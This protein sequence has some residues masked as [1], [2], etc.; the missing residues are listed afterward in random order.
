VSALGDALMDEVGVGKAYH[1][2][3]E[4]DIANLSVH[5]PRERDSWLMKEYV[6][7]NYNSDDLRRL[8]RVWLHQEVLFL[9]DVMDTGGRAINKKYLD[10]KPINESWSSLSFLIKQPATRDFKLWKAAIPQIRALGVRFHLSNYKEQG[11]KI[12]AWQYDLE[13]SALYHCKGVLVDIYEP[14]GFPGA[15]IRANRYCRVCVF[16]AYGHG[17]GAVM[18]EIPISSPLSQ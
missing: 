9:L 10:S 1:L 4:I 2:W 18:H 6:R 17:W 7:M 11:H 8:N 14:L 12:W 16:L 13:T 15:C 5:L 3:V